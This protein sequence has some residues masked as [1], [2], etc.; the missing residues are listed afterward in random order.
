MQ[1][2]IEQIAQIENRLEAIRAATAFFPD[3]NQVPQGLRADEYAAE[4][5]LMKLKDALSA[6]TAPNSV[7]TVGPARPG[8]VF[9][10]MPFKDPFNSYYRDIIRPA[11]VDIKYEIL[12]SDE[13]YSPT[14]FLQTIWDKIIASD[15]VISEMT[16]MNPN[17]LYELGLCHAISKKVIMITQ[18]I[19]FIP[20]DLRHINCVVYNTTE[21]NWVEKL[22]NAIQRMILF[23]SSGGNDHIVLR[24][25]ATVDNTIFFERLSKERDFLSEKLGRMERQNVQYS[26]YIDDLKSRLTSIEAQLA[27]AMSRTS[28]SAQTVQRM[29]RDIAVSVLLLP[30]TKALIEFVRVVSGM[31]IFGSGNSAQQIDLNEFFITRYS[32]TNL[33]F[34]EFLNQMGNQV[35]GGA[36][37]MDLNGKSS[38]D[39]C[40][41]TSAD[42]KFYVQE[43]FEQH[44]AAYVNFYGASAFCEWAG[45]C[46]PTVEQWEKAV[47]GVEGRDYPWGSQPPNSALANIKEA[48]WDRDVAPIDVH[49]KILGASPFGVVQAIGNVWHWTQTYYPDREV[50]AVRGGAFFDFRLGNRSAYR[51]H[52]QP[53]GPD[54]SQGF[55]MT[56]RF[57]SST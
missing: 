29:E 24:P 39:A 56:K 54:F 15:F 30:N 26:R 7:P 51:F 43:G 41:I 17:V 22:R 3:A 4:Q 35:E 53:N 20:S 1:D 8:T 40:R 47:R 31:F 5:E 27:A 28:H 32:I 46:L 18:N 33:Q 49:E 48:G 21:V 57:I 52:V 10:I 38:C 9:V 13:I 2:L 23:R 44:P 11:V 34:C 36:R 42:G 25:P 50:Q 6:E 16:E 45:G 12:R 55:L 14:A 19:D 37:W